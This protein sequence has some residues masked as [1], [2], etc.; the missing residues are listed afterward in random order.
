M[1][2]SHNLNVRWSQHTLK[3]FSILVGYLKLVFNLDKKDILPSTWMG[4]ELLSRL[5]QQQI[6]KYKWDPQKN[7]FI[8][9]SVSHNLIKEIT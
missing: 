6:S 5:A 3:I 7:L 9:M 2:V 1:S 4:K 8:L